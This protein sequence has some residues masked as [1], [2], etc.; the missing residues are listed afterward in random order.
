M[1]IL[2]I[3]PGTARLGYGVIKEEG[4]KLSLIEYG[5][6]EPA[7]GTSKAERLV[8]VHNKVVE[9]IE[10][11]RPGS[12]AIEKLFFFKN[13]K[14]V[15]SISEARGVV[16]SAAQMQNLQIGE[17]T[18][19]QIKQAVTGYGRAEKKQV[20]KM[21]QLILKMKEIPKPDD[22]ADALAAAICHSNFLG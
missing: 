18:P 19:L 11:H 6:L 15:L 1:V 3:D 22:A 20:Q 14:T 2:G 13:Q 8:G 12:L 7:K 5:C 10:K 9:L 17:Y 16:L 21:V 4:K